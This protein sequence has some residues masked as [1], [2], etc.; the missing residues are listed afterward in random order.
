MLL[1]L[2][3]ERLMLLQAPAVVVSVYVV[4]VGLAIG[5]LIVGEFNPVVEAS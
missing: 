4:A 5:F 1:T 2:I 3:V